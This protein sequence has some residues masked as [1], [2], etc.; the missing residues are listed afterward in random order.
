MNKTQNSVKEGSKPGVNPL[1]SK[2][3]NWSFVVVFILIIVF[4]Y[5]HFFYPHS[6][7]YE[8]FT[9]D[10][11]NTTK[12]TVS[13]TQSK[14]KSEENS[15]SNNETSL[16]LT[17][18][19]KTVY[20]IALIKLYG[21]N[22]RMICNMLPTLDKSI[23]IIG[24]KEFVR[25]HFPVH[26]IKMQDGTVIAVFNDG[27]LYSKDSVL[28]TIW[29]GPLDNSMPNSI[30]PLRMV[31]LT[32][33][34]SNLLGVGFDNKLYIRTLDKDGKFDPQSVWKPVPNNNN[35]IYVI[36]DRDT[37][38]LVSIDVKGRLF[39]KRDAELSSD[40]T[41]ITNIVLDRPLLRLYYDIHGYMLAIDNEFNL[42]QF[43]DKNWKTSGLNIERGHN[44]AKLNDI[45]YYNDGKMLG[46]A[47]VNDANMLH[48]MKQSEIYY[49]SRFIP[50]DIQETLEIE[51]INKNS[52]FLL[53]DADVIR[54][55]IGF[56]NVLLLGDNND[57]YDQDV[58]FAFHKQTLENQKKLRDFCSKRNETA[59]E[60]LYDNYDLLSNVEQNT[61]KIGLLKDV[62]DNLIKYDPDRL[63]IQEQFPALYQ[64]K[65]V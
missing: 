2:V 11:S 16:N 41:E 7:R 4:I 62:L 43:K 39:I 47:F 61:E 31:S 60:K 45:L 5:Y 58:S 44:D 52:N 54:N 65:M 29:K 57:Q 35:I 49:L 24:D 15:T 1:L 38:L 19:K 36:Y 9:D 32:T 18:L 23:C 46:L 6:K 20:E 12:T 10:I 14:I 55:K 34:L 64:P 17:K 3:I 53:N 33:D 48:T 42:Y 56:I 28:G 21:D 40:N 30:I 63:E 25:Y 37:Q 51:S 59:G 26:M 50:L 8:H 27:R 13:K 22:S